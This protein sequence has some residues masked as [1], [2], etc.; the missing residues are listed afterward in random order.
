[1]NLLKVLYTLDLNDKNQKF[2]AKP[3]LEGRMQFCNPW[4]PTNQG[5]SRSVGRQH[6]EKILIGRQAHEQDFLNEE[7][8]RSF[9]EGGSIFE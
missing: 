3:S 9:K 1:M 4:L 8:H 7:A 6:S 2:K 5:I